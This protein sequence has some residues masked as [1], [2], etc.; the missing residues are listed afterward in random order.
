MLK[1]YSAQYLSIH[2]TIKIK[3][4]IEYVSESTLA[5]QQALELHSFAVDHEPN[6]VDSNI[7]N[8]IPIKNYYCVYKN[9]NNVPTI[10]HQL[11]CYFHA[12]T[13][14]CVRQQDNILG[15]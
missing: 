1:K 10:W 8:N 3:I 9:N 5:V 4:D 13:S 11:H 6:Q 12:P 2:Q 15:Y 7:T 14:H